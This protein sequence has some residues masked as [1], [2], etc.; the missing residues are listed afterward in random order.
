MNILVVIPARGGSKG[1]PFKNIYPINSK[2]M[3]EY[4]IEAILEAKI[5]CDIVVST[6]SE[7]ISEIARKYS[8]IIIIK[9]PNEISGDFATTESSL[10]H[11]LDYMEVN[12]NKRFDYVITL[13]PTS[14]LRKSSTISKFL[15]EFQKVK[16]VYDAQL[17]LHQ[18]F[19][20]YWTVDENGEFVRLFKDAPRRRQARKPLYVENSCIYITSAKSL[21]ETNSVLGYKT[22]GFI[23]SE[24]E[25]MDI[26][27][28][29]DIKLAESYLK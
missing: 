29:N 24:V 11:A 6:D 14:P 20:D 10:I 3:I 15:E 5:E 7:K 22:N 8:S 26:N 2:P 16:N 4:T 18:S 27:E 17:T 19:S 1:I 9:R 25:G 28:Y 12:G 23:I 13:Q 21:R